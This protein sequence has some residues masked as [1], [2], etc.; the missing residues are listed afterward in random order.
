MRARACACVLERARACAY[1]CA[2]A[3]ARVC[4]RVRETAWF[5]KMC[6]VPAKLHSFAIP[7]PLKIVFSRIVVLVY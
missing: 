3:R 7:K 4:V 5:E 2:F 6:Q 1:V